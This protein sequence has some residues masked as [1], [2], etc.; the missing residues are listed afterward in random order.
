MGVSAVGAIVLGAP[1]FVLV[2]VSLR[3][4]FP[5]FMLGTVAALAG[6]TLGYVIA[7]IV[8]RSDAR[9]LDIDR[10]GRIDIDGVGGDAP[11]EPV[12]RGYWVPKARERSTGD[13]EPRRD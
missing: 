4:F 10:V 6:L 5:A 1:T 9:R 12:R 2:L 13:D 8:W 3:E 7:R 11:A